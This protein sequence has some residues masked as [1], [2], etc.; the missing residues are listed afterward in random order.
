MRFIKEIK[1]SKHNEQY[2][3]LLSIHPFLFYTN[4]KHVLEKSR[5]ADLLQNLKVTGKCFPSY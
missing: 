3:S 4:I 2:Y 1:P 5:I